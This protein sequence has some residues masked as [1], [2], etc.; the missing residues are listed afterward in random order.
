MLSRPAM[1]SPKITISAP[2]I[3][4]IQSRYWNSSW[5][6]A[7]KEAPSATN[8]SEKPSTKVTACSSTRRRAAAVRSVDRSATDMPVMKDKYD[9]NSGRTQGERKEKSPA[10]NATTT[11]R[12][13][14]PITASPKTLGASSPGQTLDNGVRGVAVPVAGA[15]GE[16]R[17]VAVAGDDEA[18]GQRA[19]GVAVGQIHLRVQRDRER[20]L[21]L[22]DERR[23]LLGLGVD[24]HG[25][26]RESRRLLLPVQPLHRRHLL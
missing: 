20:Q 16:R 24:R 7:L 17:E 15:D 11:P 22:G 19:H 13:A 14:A 1:Y 25:H 8:T 9:G 26:Q 4:R 2:P 10:L 21:V 18:R 5:P 12:E 23:H 3:R 6:A